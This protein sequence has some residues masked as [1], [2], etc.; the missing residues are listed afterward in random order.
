[1]RTE[2]NRLV[3]TRL[4]CHQS[5]VSFAWQAL[6]ILALAAGGCASRSQEPTRLPS[7]PEIAL[8]P[9]L[10]VMLTWDAPVDL[11]LYLTDPSAETVYFANTP[12][13]SGARLARDTRCRDVRAAP[14]PYVEVVH[15]PEPA[16]GRYRVGVDFMET[17]GTEKAPV[18]FRTVV[19][20]DGS[21]QDTVGTV[22][23]EEF[24]PIVL[25]FELRQ[26]AP[27]GRPML[28]REDR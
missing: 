26:P 19:Q 10:N 28:S 24:Q 7:A 13:R 23:L 27:G 17:C 3:C 18:S 2:A 12:S 25:E 22:R 5:A 6:A 9:G 11:D 14:G 16:P 15:V 4:R 21:R 8:E 20:L 1:M